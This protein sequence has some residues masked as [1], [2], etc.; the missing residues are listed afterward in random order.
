VARQR[1]DRRGAGS[2]RG[3]DSGQHLLLGAHPDELSY[4]AVR[5]P[6]VYRRAGMDGGP[7][8]HTSAVASHRSRLNHGLR[9]EKCLARDS[10]HFLYGT[11]QVVDLRAWPIG[12]YLRRRR[13]MRLLNWSSITAP[14]KRGHALRLPWRLGRDQVSEPTVKGRRN[15]RGV[16]WSAELGGEHQPRLLPVVAC[17]Q[18]LGLLLG[19][20]LAQHRDN[21][22]RDRHETSN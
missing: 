20:V 22:G 1:R 21:G 6:S 4:L 5:R 17:A 12:T 10:R 19:A 8:P 16:N 3:R 13:S 7:D 11:Y 9:R 2:V 15:L 14:P 18:P